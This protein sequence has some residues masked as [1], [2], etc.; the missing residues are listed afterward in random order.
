MLDEHS[1]HK[2]ITDPDGDQW[3]KREWMA[4]DSIVLGN[5]LVGSVPPDHL[6]VMMLP[7]G[8]ILIWGGCWICLPT[9]WFMN[10]VG[11]ME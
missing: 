3:G 7:S 2:P 5:F 1:P 8:I 10:I 9:I 4:K 6:T 11:D